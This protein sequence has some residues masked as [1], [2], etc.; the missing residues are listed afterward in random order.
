MMLSKT[1]P[2]VVKSSDVLGEFE[3]FVSVMGV[4]DFYG[5]VVQPGAFDDTLAKW[6]DS[7]NP[8][9]VV[10]SHG[11]HDVLN[12]IGYAL[13]AEQ[14]TISGKTGL[15]VRGQLDVTDA[16]EDA[17][18]RKAARLMKSGRVSQF[19]FSYEVWDGAP[20]KSEEFGDYY[21]LN[22]LGLYEVGPTLIGANADTELLAAKALRDLAVEL[23]SG[24]VLSAKNEELLR[25]AHESIGSVLA[26]LEN[27]NDGKAM[28][29][30][31]STPMKAVDHTRG[32]A[33]RLALEQLE[34]GLLIDLRN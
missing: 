18:A 26:A 9:P 33:S 1:A 34:V 10:W 11:Y 23:K 14:R 25:A 28:T 8:I 30:G 19:S 20:A 24:R 13:E 7:G 17:R 27:S 22:R 15:W 3:A 6:K 5:D 4:K 29:G 2:A 32:A 16:E 21:S 31:P 12:H